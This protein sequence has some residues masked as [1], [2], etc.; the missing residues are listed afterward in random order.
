MTNKTN[1]HINLNKSNLSLLNVSKNIMDIDNIKYYTPEK[2]NSFFFGVERNNYLI[3]SV[4][5]QNFDL[6]KRKKS[7]SKSHK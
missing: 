1:E 4:I 3:I 5:Q 7:K 2:L 6:F